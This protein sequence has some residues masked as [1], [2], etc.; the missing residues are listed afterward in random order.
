ME[1]EKTAELRRQIGVLAQVTSVDKAV[2]KQQSSMV[3]TEIKVK[4]KKLEKLAKEVAT[5]A[6]KQ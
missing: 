5:H 1:A 4:H 6:N 3:A 2:E